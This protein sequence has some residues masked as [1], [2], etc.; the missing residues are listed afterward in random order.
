MILY[1]DKQYE[2]AKDLLELTIK[3]GKKGIM[4]VFNYSTKSSSSFFIYDKD[5]EEEYY[6]FLYPSMDW[7]KEYGQLLED[8]K[9]IVEK[10]E[11]K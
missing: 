3:L 4:A 7:S 11:E 9:P 8:I 10:L 1:S 6:R 2:V 5:F